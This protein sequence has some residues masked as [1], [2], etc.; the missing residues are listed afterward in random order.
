MNHTNLSARRERRIRI[1]QNLKG[2]APLSVASIT[3]ITEEDIAKD[4]ERIVKQRLKLEQ[5]IEAL[6]DDIDQVKDKQE[7]LEENLKEHVCLVE[8]LGL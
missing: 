3:S 1:N 8:S 4:L 2:S 5:K 7:E 6:I